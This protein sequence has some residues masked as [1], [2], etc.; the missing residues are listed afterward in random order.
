MLLTTIRPSVSPEMIEKVT[1]LY[2]GTIHDILN[3]VFQNSRRA[4]ATR[5]I[6]TTE[7]SENGVAFTIIDDGEGIAD[8][9]K[10]LAL[11]T[12]AWSESVRHAEDSAG[13]GFYA[14]AG[15]DTRISTRNRNCATAWSVKI[16]ADAW[17]GTQD[18][19]LEQIECPIGTTIQF[20]IPNLDLSVADRV[21]SNA[22][23]YYPL[24]VHHNTVELERKNFLD[25]AIHTVEFEGTRIGVF[26]G[27]NSDHSNNVNF[28]GITL[29]AKL[30]SIHESIGS[31]TY[32]VRFDVHTTPDLRLVL[33]SRKE[34]VQ[35]KSLDKLCQAATKAIFEA[36]SLAEWH[37]L[38]YKNWRRARDHGIDL[39]EAKQELWTW[40]P[41]TAEENNTSGALT[42]ISL[43]TTTS[44]L[45]GNLPATIAIP[46]KHAIDNQDEQ[47]AIYCEHQSYEGYKWYDALHAIKNPRFYVSKDSTE[48]II[49]ENGTFPP[50]TTHINADAIELRYSI[51]HA[52]TETETE[53]RIST[54]VAFSNNDDVWSDGISEAVIA[55]VQSE[56]L[57]QY[58]LAS[59]L[60]DAFFIPS[61]DHDFDSWDTQQE[62]F[63]RDAQELTAT[64]LYGPDEAACELIKNQISKILY[65]LPTEKN[66]VVTI[67]NGKTA[68][69]ID[70]QHPDAP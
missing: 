39:P 26:K 36:I 38:S 17:T 59:L 57:D 67:Q 37:H 65:S 28:H 20:T 12:S 35:N 31:Q 11:G 14:L 4:K 63:E 27:Y 45:I 61:D 3:E 16:P 48:V 55:F 34:F 24:P 50:Q 1:R 30:P 70:P 69:A 8:P 46:F 32:F 51:T 53:R 2:N 43:P 66:F 40:D 49:A 9:N 21:V 10:L 6:V 5:I 13:M 7:A 42:D 56:N 29:R 62:R 23:I 52:P 44:V 47:L 68:V 58:T 33:P 19:K 60:E 18:L 22:A 64:L 54:D 15:K 41:D 25:K